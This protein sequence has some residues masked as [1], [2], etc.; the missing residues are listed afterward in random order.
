[1]YIEGCLCL[2][3]FIYLFWY[4]Q[5]QNFFIVFGQTFMLDRSCEETAKLVRLESESH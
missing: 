5:S 1:M 3:K 4:F 2:I